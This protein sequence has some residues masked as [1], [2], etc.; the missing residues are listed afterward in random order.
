MELREAIGPK[1][2][3]GGSVPIFLRRPTATCDLL[4]GAWTPVPHIAFLSSPVE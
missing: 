3:G 2:G 1:G 4:G